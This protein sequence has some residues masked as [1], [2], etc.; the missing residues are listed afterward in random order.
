[1]ISLFRKGNPELSSNYRLISLLPITSK[2]FENFMY[3]GPYRFLEIHKVLYSFQFGFQENHSKNHALVSVT[4][5][6]R[7]TLDNKGFGDGIFSDLQ[8][9][10][11]T[12]NRAVLLS[13]LQ[14]GLCKFL[15]TNKQ[16]NKSTNKQKRMNRIHRQRNCTRK[17]W[18]W[19]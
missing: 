14:L 9:S 16:T 7:N 1:M 19:S 13:N 4:E 3:R 12:V 17:L 18:F 8:K 10:F 11:D 5:T 6:V 15:T 2:I